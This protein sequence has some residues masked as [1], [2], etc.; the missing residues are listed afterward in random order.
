[1]YRREKIF[2]NT[3]KSTKHVEKE[4]ERAGLF[5]SSNIPGWKEDRRKLL[6][7]TTSGFYKIIATQTSAQTMQNLAKKKF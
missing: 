2:Q 4:I 3:V 7:N 1:M 5:S 6:L